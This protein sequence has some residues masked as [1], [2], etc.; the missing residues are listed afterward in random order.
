MVHDFPSAV[1]L[2]HFWCFSSALCQVFAILTTIRLLIIL[3]IS[4]YYASLSHFVAFVAFIS[5]YYDA[6]N[7][8]HLVKCWLIMNS[9]TASKENTKNESNSTYILMKLSFIAPFPASCIHVHKHIVLA[10]G[11]PCCFLVLLVSHINVSGKRCALTGEIPHTCEAI[12]PKRKWC[13]NF[14]KVQF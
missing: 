2:Q 4:H 11:N 5:Q 13:A 6:F 8:K 7:Q 12:H 14:A 10:T 3:Q 1:W 9:S